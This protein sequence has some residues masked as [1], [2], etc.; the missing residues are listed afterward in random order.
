MIVVDASALA[1]FILREEV[2]WRSISNYIKYCISVDHVVKE[3]L[4]TIWKAYI[5]REFIDLDGAKKAYN[6][7]LSLIGR[8][9][10]LEPE[11][12]YIDKA[13]EISIEN[14][15]TV[16]D[17]LYIALALDKQLP[18]LTLDSQQRRIAQQLGVEVVRV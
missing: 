1:A 15:I 16:Y 9:L 12:N 8:N 14:R 6:L 7:L 13:Y 11:L 18:L 2:V 3:V 4:N 5:L 17:S 10:L